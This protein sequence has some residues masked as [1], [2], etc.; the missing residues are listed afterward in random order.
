MSGIFLKVLNMSIAAGWLI[1]AVILLRL[2]LKKA[3]KWTVCLL[4]ALAALRLV[5]PF[6]LESIFSLI[7]SSE[8]VP[9]NIEMM[10]K[11]AIDSGIG[12]I[13]EVV[14]PVVGSFAPDQNIPASVNPLQIVVPLL[15]IV[16]L[17]GI[18]AMLIYALISYLKLK[19]SVAASVPAEDGVMACDEVS[20]PFIL[21]VFRP[22]IY[23]PSGMEGET[24]EYV[25]DHERAHLARRDHLWKPLGFLILAVHWFNPLCWIAYV[26]LCRDIEAACDEKVIR[27]M[28]KEAVAAYSQALLDCSFPRKRIAACPLAFGEVGVKER[29]KNVLNYKK[30]AFWIILAAVV[31]CIVSAVCFLTNPKKDKE[32]TDPAET[33]RVFQAVVT[34]SGGGSMYIRPLVGMSELNSGTRFSVPTKGLDFEPVPGDVL[35]IDYNGLI[36]EVYPCRL[37]RIWSI[38]RIEEDGTESKEFFDRLTWVAQEAKNDYLHPYV[39]FEGTKWQA[40]ADRAVSF[41]V[42]GEFTRVGDRIEARLRDSASGP[43]DEAVSVEFK[44]LSRYEMV[45]TKVS[46][47]MA[48]SLGLTAGDY[49]LSSLVNDSN[50]YEGGNGSVTFRSPGVYWNEE[51]Y[52]AYR[53]PSGT[54]TSLGQVH[55][56]ISFSDGMNWRASAD[57]GM[58]FGIGGKYTLEGDRILLR[59]QRAMNA[60]VDTETTI[61]LQILSETEL[62]VV[63]ATE[64]AGAVVIQEGAVFV[65]WN[66][67]DLSTYSHVEIDADPLPGR[68]Y[69]GE[70]VVIGYATKIDDCVEIKCRPYIRFEEGNK[71]SGGYEAEA[72][73]Y[74]AEGEYLQDGNRIILQQ[75]KGGSSGAGKEFFAELQIVSDGTLKIVRL[76][77]TVDPSYAMG[78]IFTLRGENAGN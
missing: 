25:L 22:T 44:I 56:C 18:A 62:K 73:S 24:R 67:P 59:Q 40:G 17:A 19:K 39:Y 54:E 63:K 61:E 72:H 32:P 47:E 60:P 69:D 9:A 48:A 4:W 11:P 15:G 43:A 77:Q 45:V 41:F 36:Q 26:L 75:T 16:W 20:S 1:L 34:E 13:N 31:I 28:D 27:S 12:V 8:T 57:I 78:E 49:L 53:E 37:D 76:P 51:G 21:G 66:W 35:E 64:E 7:P 23:L 3:P 71:W 6:S 29:V 42:G 55:P 46:E 50:D 33:H 30:P 2:L 74:H 70:E 38:R 65:Y 5:V 52:P 10:G 68:I 58:S 14:N